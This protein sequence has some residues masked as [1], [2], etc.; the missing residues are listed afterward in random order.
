MPMNYLFPIT[1]MSVTQATTALL[2]VLGLIGHS[3]VAADIGIVQGATLATFFSFSANSRNIIF[4]GSRQAAI[5]DILSLRLLLLLPL[6]SF[7]YVLSVNGAHVVSAMALFLIVRRCGEWISEV[8][9]SSMEVSRDHRSAAI[10]LTLQIMGFFLAVAVFLA[11]GVTRYVG[12]YVWAMLPFMQSLPFLLRHKPSRLT[13]L[14]AVLPGLLPHF[15]STLIIGITIYVFRLAILVTAGKEATGVLLTAFALGG[16]AG[17]LFANVVGPS[18]A[19]HEKNSGEAQLPRE[20]KYAI[21]SLAIIGCVL[22]AGAW[23]HWPDLSGL[24]KS[25]M[26]W[27]ATGLSLL[28]GIVMIF[29]QRIRFRM[30][31]AGD[32]TDVFGA[33]VMA[34]IVL[35]GTVPF[36]YYMGGVDLLATLYFLNTGF[37]YVFYHMA[38]RRSVR[39]GQSVE[40]M[41]NPTMGNNIMLILGLAIFFPLFFQFSGFVFR[42]EVTIFDSGGGLATLP[43]PVSILAT[44]A[45]IA[46]LASYRNTRL[47]FTLIIVF[48]MFMLG[49]SVVTSGGQFLDEKRKLLLLLQYLLPFFALVLGNAFASQELAGRQ[50]AEKAAFWAVATLVPLQILASWAQGRS[51]LSPYLYL[52]S[53]YQHFQFV[54]V[55]MVIAFLFGL[56]SLWGIR[57]YQVLACLMTPLVGIYAYMSYSLLANFAIVFGTLCFAILRLGWR[58]DKVALLPILLLT[59]VMGMYLT[60]RPV[61]KDSAHY[62]YDQKIGTLN[63]GSAARSELPANVSRRLDDWV[64]YSQG[65]TASV[66]TSL[67]GHAKPLA[68]EVSTSAH[69]YYLDLAYNY[70]VLALIPIFFLI[71]YTLAMLFKHRKR[72]LSSDGLL[73]LSA[74]VLFLALIDSNLKVT[75]RQPYSGIVTFF[76]WGLLLTRLGGGRE[77][78]GHSTGNERMAKA[79]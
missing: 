43:L 31:S 61:A 35:V 44:F 73:C 32:G 55:I 57:K 7:A 40:I 13:N 59:V 28:G 2:I 51:E 34:N 15:G 66:E 25:D 75:L 29:A 22:L 63:I 78:P 68:R 1:F 52:F 39:S 45:G 3:E 16:F 23:I 70:G 60:A 47:S 36:A 10:F 48:F 79:S 65:I 49:A 18:I 5:G 17:S 12:M 77:W 64:F 4:E 50:P 74:L 76:L 20:I 38:D 58:R 42:A 67:F 69:N 6:A 33:D 56:Y 8:H 14:G 37:L 71:A 19:L 46:W 21:Y 26:F 53:V 9:I 24:G 54:P 72:I 30:I 27:A 62:V 11:G 41:G